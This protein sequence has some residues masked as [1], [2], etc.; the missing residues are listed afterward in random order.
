ML[1]TRLANRYTILKTLGSGGFG[2]TYLARD[3][4]LS[5]GPTPATDV[6]PSLCVVKQLKPASHD[7]T[8]LKVARRLFETEV[9]TLRKLGQHDRI[10][11]LLDSFE[12]GE[13]F[14]L[15]QEFIEGLPLGEEFRLRDRLSEADVIALLEDVLPVMQF[16]HDNH[17]IHRDIKPGNLIRRRQD[18]KLVLIDFGA[19]KEIRTQ[20][21]S[22]EDSTLTVGIG[23]QGYTPPEQLTG[24]PRYGSDLYALGMT[25][26][27]ALTGLSP[28]QMAEDPQTSEIV[29]QSHADA[30]IGLKLVLSKL[31]R[32]SYYYRYQTTAEVLHD[33]TRL[34]QISQ[35]FAD[36]QDFTVPW[37]V[38]TI[39]PRK[40]RLRLLR[41]LAVTTLAA[42]GLVLGIRQVGG[43]Q[44]VELKLYDTLVQQQATSDPD[45]RLLIVEITE[46]DLRQ[47]QRATPSDQAI[48]DVIQTLQAFSPRAIG[49]DLHREIAQPPG[50][51][52]LIQALQADNTIVIT[53]LGNTADETIPPPESIPPERVGFNDFP[54]DPDNVI[55]RSFLFL[56]RDN[57]PD[58][59]VLLS[60]S[61]QLALKYLA[62]DGINSQASDQNPNHM[63]LGEAV[64]KP[65][66]ATAGNYQ[67]IDGRGD[68]ILLDYHSPDQ[69]A[70][71]VSLSEVL[72][73]D[74]D[75]TWV[76]GK[77]VLIGMTASSGRDLFYTPYSA[78]LSDEHQMAG[79]VVHANMV[80]QI[81][82]VALG[83]QVL[84]WFWPNWVEAIWIVGW[85]LIGAAI[86]R[87][88]HRSLW[89]GIVTAGSFVMIVG[90]AGVCFI[91]GGWIP[92]FAPA[93]AVLLGGTTSLAQ[94][95]YRS[96]AQPQLLST[97][98]AQS[99]APYPDTRIK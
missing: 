56:G 76:E 73:G 53:K 92:I 90:I 85:A 74:F 24:K 43:F 37:D 33:L 23:T 10:P 70:R 69:V 94:R 91:Q 40:Q 93:V 15:V 34:E 18:G 1:G 45:P 60:F 29:W 87:L 14:Y 83:E 32:H 72:A 46:A 96:P 84:P 63:R 80:H 82:A 78:K 8:F 57:Q 36:L 28:G 58:S 19:V 51:D 49:L 48:A 54:A 4:Q 71:R 86:P 25:A 50:H 6:A 3:E 9:K 21:S 11:Q 66:T 52:A 44:A 31:I 22:G 77:I 67:T 79:V 38:S 98:W 20:L 75:P 61:L 42:A 55:R 30:S 13:E 88:L 26:I 59:E 64:F 97:S 5:P 81:L 62:A 65:L 68:D 47:Q 89:V 99:T 7:P 27:Q 12:D 17:V 39:A 2:Q 35:D 41:N 95:A 16:V